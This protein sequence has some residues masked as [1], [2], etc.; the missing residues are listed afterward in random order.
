M[1][2]MLS[3]LFLT[4]ATVE[5]AA[6]ARVIAGPGMV[7]CAELAEAYRRNPGPTETQF[8]A[9]AQGFMSAINEPRRL[10]NEPTRDLGGIPTAS[11]KQLLRSFCDQ[12]PL[13]NFIEAARALYMSFPENPPRSN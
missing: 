5:A 10:R 12:R 9:W 6:Q 13:A 7:P 3:A 4:L 11:Q 8:F 2:R 1:R